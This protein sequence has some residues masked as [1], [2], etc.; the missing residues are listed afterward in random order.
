MKKYWGWLAAVAMA[1]CAE[2][3]WRS[4]DVFA[5]EVTTVE[6]VRSILDLAEF[7]LPDEA[8]L[9]QPK[10]LATLGYTAPG[11]AVGALSYVRQHIQARAWEELPGAVSSEPFASATFVKEGYR[12]QVTVTL[13]TRVAGVQVTISHLGKLKF[14]ELPLNFG[15][16]PL[17]SGPVTAV[18]VSDQPVE[19]TVSQ[20]DTSLRAA[21]WRP[22]GLSSNIRRYLK[23]ITV[24]NA[25]I[26]ESA[27]QA[28]KTSIS[29]TSH[30]ISY[31]QQFPEDSESLQY[32]DTTARLTFESRQPREE[33]LPTYRAMLQQD[34]WQLTEEAVRWIDSPVDEVFR[35]PNGEVLSVHVRQEQ[36]RSIVSVRRFTSAELESHR[37]AGQGAPMSDVGQ[38]GQAPTEWKLVIPEGALEVVENPGQWEFKLPAGK[39]QAWL[40]KWLGPLR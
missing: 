16:R 31:P 39:A 32:D 38:P 4:V 18:F 23:G 28:D 12:V 30:I 33:M 25:L 35:H 6:Q 34:G 22:F 36:G 24:L 15:V 20:F 37:P 14:D 27:S 13:S 7:P 26:S 9:T 11:D 5:Q 8:K 40:D 1:L 17:F 2:T 3:G 29:L 21:G 19:A 10:R